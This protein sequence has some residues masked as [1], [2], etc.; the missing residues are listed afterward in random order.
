MIMSSSASTVT[1]FDP[2]EL[3]TDDEYAPDIVI[4]SS[5]DELDHEM[6]SD[7]DDLLD[8]FQPFAL[9][10]PLVGDDPQIDDVLD[11]QLPLFDR[12]IY[13]HPEGEHVVVYLAIPL[14][15]IPPNMDIE[16]DQDEVPLF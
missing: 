5:D 1:D 8:D 13:G 4:V 2:M 16:D 15:A 3:L 11:L 9:P 6:L 10:D 7:D 14:A 12:I